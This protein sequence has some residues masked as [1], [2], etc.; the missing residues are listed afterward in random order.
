MKTV[1]QSNMESDFDNL[2]FSV[3]Q[4]SRKILWY[5]VNYTM[6][7]AKIEEERTKIT[8]AI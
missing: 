7:A 8:F 3:Y 2:L 6:Y 1:R 4:F 5:F